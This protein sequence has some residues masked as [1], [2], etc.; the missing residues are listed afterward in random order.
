MILDKSMIIFIVKNG[1]KFTSMDLLFG[2]GSVWFRY[3]V[4]ISLIILT[5][6]ILNKFI[7]IQNY[8][9]LYFMHNPIFQKLENTVFW[10]LDF[11]Y[12]VGS[13]RKS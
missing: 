6:K 1:R 3:D 12:P 5:L 8:W 7:F 11:S 2:S 10:K 4:R 13:L 9:V